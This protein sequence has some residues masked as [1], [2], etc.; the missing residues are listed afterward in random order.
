MTPEKASEREVDLKIELLSVHVLHI[1]EDEDEDEIQDGIEVTL[2]CP[3][4]SGPIGIKNW[5]NLDITSLET[6]EYWDRFPELIEIGTAEDSG[7]W[8]QILWEIEGTF[9]I[10]EGMPISEAV[11]RLLFDLD[12]YHDF[13]EDQVHVDD[14]RYFQILSASELV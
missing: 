1:N 9:I 12:I 14:V 5:V 2:Q 11:E 3:P 4:W 13:S 7:I 8:Q 10:P 6:N